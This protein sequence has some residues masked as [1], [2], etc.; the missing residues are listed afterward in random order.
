M[1]VNPFD[2]VKAINEKKE[3]ENTAEYVPYLS[4]IAF[5]YSMDTILLANEMN[6]YPNLPPEV[7]FDFMW[8]TVRK[9]RRYAKWYKEDEHPH[10]QTVM[11]YYKYSKQKAL[12]ALQ[13][14]FRSSL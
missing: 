3:V 12:A 4:N 8:Y 7:Q 9:G 14:S 11:E 6:Q 1:A 13:T 10:L 5:S 2:L